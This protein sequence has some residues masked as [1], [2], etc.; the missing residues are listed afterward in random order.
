MSLSS[1]G[2]KVLVGTLGSDI[3][4]LATVEKPKGSEDEDEGEEEASLIVQTISH[5]AI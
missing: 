3:L 4:E 1:D 5:A 2:T